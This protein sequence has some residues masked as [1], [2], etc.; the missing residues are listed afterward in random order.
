MREGV[1]I[2]QV[3][4]ELDRHNLLPAIVFRTSRSQCDVDAERAGKNPR[5]KLSPVL[6][7]ELH[8]KVHKIAESYE[9]DT[10]LITSHP[11]YNSLITTGIG[12]HH[13]GQLL[14]WRLLLEELMAAGL[15]RTLVATGTVA[16]GVDFPARTVVITAHSKR[17]S[18]GFRPLTSAEFQQMSGRAGRRGKDTVGFCV[19]A[20][21]PFNDARVLLNIAK[22][23][24]EPLV[25]AYFPGPSTV[26]NLL[27]Y[28]TVD[29]LQFTVQ[30][31][32][33]AFI[34]RREAV[35]LRDQAASFA[36]QLPSHLAPRVTAL[37][38]DGLADFVE[39]SQAEMA[40]LSKDEKKLLKKVRRYFRE[41]S[42]LE[43]RQVSLL[44]TA[45]NGLRELNYLEGMH[46][47]EKGMWAANLC[48]NLVLE[49]G[50]IIQAE[51]FKGASAETLVAVVA[52]ISADSYRQYLNTK[53]FALDKEQTAKVT[54]ILNR[55]T[56]LDMPGVVPNRTVNMAA[57]NTA[58][59]WLQCEDWQEFRALLTLSGVAEGDAARLI[60]QTAEQLNQL[61]RL[62]QTHSELAHR[63]EEGKRRLLRP[64]LTEQLN[65]D[66]E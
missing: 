35:V 19:A 57:A 61:T 33:A 50:E 5:L 32:L 34:D 58:L 38:Q 18:D 23:P 41:A 60:T 66:S 1:H 14:M 11:H 47:S 64:P 54:E 16:A 28:R 10:E 21:S 55:I 45:L 56:K 8:A 40:A 30:R 26:L 9:M 53:N 43:T 13:A 65:L 36:A 2:A 17:G 63:S 48:T 52:A 7:R 24:P 15:L 49:L 12:A 42:V 31:S 20:P 25:S 39:P 29:G 51:L 59:T 62:S 4:E 6:Q 22:Q 37:R 44:D 27:R 46:L 3:V